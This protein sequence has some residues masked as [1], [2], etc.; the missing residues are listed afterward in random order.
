[1]A[2]LVPPTT[3]SDLL[4]LQKQMPGRRP[5]MTRFKLLGPRFRGDERP[6]N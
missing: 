4:S 2:E 1:M 3:S 5:G 6:E